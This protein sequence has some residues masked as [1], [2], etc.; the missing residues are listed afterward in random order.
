[1]LRVVGIPAE[2]RERHRLLAELAEWVRLI[3]G[4]GRDADDLAVAGDDAGSKQPVVLAARPAPE[5]I[6]QGEGAE[7]AV[8]GV[9][10][11]GEHLHRT[12]VRLV[13]DLALDDRKPAAERRQAGDVAP[14]LLED[15]R[16]LIAGGGDDRDLGE[17][18]GDQ[19]VEAA[20]GEQR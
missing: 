20:T 5:L 11:S 2:V 7:P 16:G 19:L 9:G 8:Q 12:A 1:M 15:D 10:V 17:W 13:P 4:G 14:R 6:D 18:S 3:V